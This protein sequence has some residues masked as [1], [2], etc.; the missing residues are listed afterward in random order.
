MIAIVDTGGANLYSVQSAMERL[1]VAYELT[2]DP[3][4]IKKA[5]RVLLPGVGSAKDSMTRLKDLGL[6]PVIQSL[7]QPVL[8]ICL[9]MQ[10]LFESS[11]EGPTPCLSLL[12]GA[13]VPITP[14]ADLTLPHMGWNR[15]AIQQKDHPLLRG[16]GEDSYV[17]FVHSFRAPSSEATVASSWHG[18]EIPAVVQLGNFYG[19]QFHPERSGAV[20][21]KILENFL[22]C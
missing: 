10:L 6:I 2:V 12:P 1:Q 5:P 4:V 21:Q 13:V 15:L 9:G 11:L 14:R 3:K 20:G 22:S 8:G 7:T 16:V 17:Y 18:E 19:C